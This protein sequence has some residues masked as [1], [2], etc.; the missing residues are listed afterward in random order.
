MTGPSG[1]AQGPLHW[2]PV[3]AE[4]LRPCL[5]DDWSRVRSAEFGVDDLHAADVANAA[6]LS[7]PTVAGDR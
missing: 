3:A 6:H 7:S 1:L 5:V 4:D 2:L